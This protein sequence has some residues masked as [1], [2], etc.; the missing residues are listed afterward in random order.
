V[1][2]S[3]RSVEPVTLTKVWP[4]RMPSRIA[5]VDSAPAHTTVVGYPTDPGPEI[6]AGVVVVA[7]TDAGDAET[8]VQVRLPEGDTRNRRSGIA[9][10]D[11]FHDMDQMPVYIWVWMPAATHADLANGS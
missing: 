6:S 7:A 9:G 4:P 8:L 3:T 10:I 5:P 2:S 1:N 11:G